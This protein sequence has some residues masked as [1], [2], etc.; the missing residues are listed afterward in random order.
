MFAGLETIL[1]GVWLSMEIAPRNGMSEVLTPEQVSLVFSGPKLIVAL[2]AGTLMALAFQFLLTNFSLAVGILSLGTDS[3]SRS[4]SSTW[5]GTI[6]KVEAKIG[7]WALITASIALFIACFLAVKLSL[8]ESMLLGAI[9]GVVIWST[10]FTLVVWLGSSTLS[11]FVGAFINT[12]NAGLQAILGTASATIGANVAKKQAVS[13]AEEITDAV[14]RELTSGFD[15][16]GIKN[17]LQSSLKS[18]QIPQLNLP[19]I[20]QQFDKIL[21]DLDLESIGDGDLLANIN[22]QTFIDLISSQVNL[23]KQQINQIADQLEDAWTQVVARKNPTEQVINL[24]KSATPEELK[25]ENLGERLQELVGIKENGNGRNSLIKQGMQYG[26]GAAGT[27]VLNR[28]DFSDIDI[29]KITTQVQKLRDKV[30]DIDVEQITHQLEDIRNKT[31]GQISARFPQKPENTIKADV[32][33][34][35]LNSLPW[36]FN[37]ITIRDEFQEVIYD[38]Q[39]DPTTTRRELAEINQENFRTWLK[40]RGDISDARV[41][42]IT[43]QM[44]RVREEVLEI[45]Q[46]AEVREKGEELRLRVENYLRST[47]KAELKADAIERNFSSL[48][49]D[50]TDLELRLQGCDRD[51]FLRLLLQRQ[52]LSEAEADHIVSQLESICE[53]ILHQERERQ[54]KANQLWQRIE[55]YLRHTNK[56]ELNPEGIKREFGTLL[57]QPEVGINLIRDRLSHFNRD[58]VVK[59]L[60]QRQDLREEEVNKIFDQIQSV[61]NRIVQLPQT[62][63]DQL[64]EYLRNTNLEELNPEGIRGDLETLL[65]DP[66]EGALAFR[67]RLSQID[68]DT[69]VKL[70]SQSQDLSEEQVNQRIDQVQKAISS[71]IKA[72]RRYASRAAQRVTDFE[73]H[74][75]NYLRHTDKEELNPES[76]KRDLQLLLRDPQVGMGNLGDRL[77]KF[78]RSTI[79]ALISEREDISEEE[80]NRIVDQIESARDTIVNQ[81]QEIQ[82]R[83]QSVIDGVFGKIRDYLNSLE[84]PE[85][86]YEGIQQDFTKLFDDPQAGFEALRDRLSQFDRDTL[87]AI[88][89]SREDI[90]PEDANRIIDQI[91]GARDSVLQRGERIQQEVQKRLEAVQEQAKKQAEETKRI[92]ANAAWWLFGTAVTSLFASAIAG[93]LATQL[94]YMI[95]IPP[96]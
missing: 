32:E 81:F 56:D 69:L 18:L 73:A 6:R 9:M 17:S 58:T 51:A 2:L 38:P 25:S 49:Q 43:H 77:A 62:T 63:V 66:R 52:D 79:V 20:R 41:T 23:S 48:L 64:A 4:E 7:F 36:H 89:S 37:R 95:Y 60:S 31:T 13:T 68:R 71:I 12:T 67:H 78:D 14:R 53:R 45:V 93:A 28:V 83:L 75:E 59:L 30:Q 16:E 3:F 33:D 61:G 92:V 39:A 42:E 27:A 44:E 1:Q 85:L 24:L 87:V 5:G 21:S 82:Q 40:Q 91:E 19:D 47:S 80:A 11:S 84:R 46:E 29:E 90:S 96:M 22:R 76:I 8:I 65:A 72:P 54:A 15:G 55:D 57:E 88:L 35:I 34:Y 50:F 86:N 74:L 10:Y 94:R 70:L 26:L